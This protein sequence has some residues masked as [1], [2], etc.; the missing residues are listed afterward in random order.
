MQGFDELK[1]YRGKDIP[2]TEKIIVTQ[3]TLEEIVEFGEAEYFGAVHILTSVGADLKAQLWDLGIDYTEIADYDL[4]LD[5][6]QYVLGSQKRDYIKIIADKQAYD[7]YIKTY[8][9]Q[10]LE[11]MNVNPLELIFK[12]LDF[13]DFEVFYDEEKKQRILYNEDKDITIDKFVYLRMVELVR[14]IHG[15][16]RNNERP[17]NERTKMDLIEDARDELMASSIKEYHSTLL[18]MI[19]ALT[20]KTGQ[21][22][23]DAI[24]HMPIAQFLENVKRATKIQQ[25][26]LLLQGAY[27]GFADI[28]GVDANSLSWFGDLNE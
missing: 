8:G 16:K 11:K 27:S 23:S 25:A 18:P 15:Y 19:S 26:D 2:V 9:V 24:W 17:A 5:Y 3:P 13:S 20:V 22:G 7:E 1:I 12:D 6:I 10:E 14:K 28:K 21:C 4:F